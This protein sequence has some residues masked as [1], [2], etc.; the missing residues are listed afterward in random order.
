M[1]TERGEGRCGECLGFRVVGLGFTIRLTVQGLEF[2]VYGLEFRVCLGF[3]G[4]EEMGNG[5]RFRMLGFRF[6]GLRFGAGLMEN[7]E[8]NKSFGE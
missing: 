8:R 6:R 5:K 4:D 2:R 7:G 1:E 3:A